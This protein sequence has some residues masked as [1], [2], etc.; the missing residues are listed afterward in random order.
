MTERP[1][2]EPKVAEA[3]VSLDQ[4][5][6]E[7]SALLPEVLKDFDVEYGAAV[8]EVVA[9]VK[10]E[11]I[12]AVCRTLKTDPTVSL[13]YLRCISCVDYEERLEV[14]YHLFSRE[15][16][17]RLVLK[18]SV[19]PDEP[20]VPSVVSIWSGADWF[21]REGHELYGV[22]FQE[23]PNLIPLLLWEGFDGYPG[24]KSFPFHEY[25]EW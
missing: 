12:P 1:K 3:P 16:S 5:G 10:S 17:Y 22:V 13:S 8:D 19:S 9:T 21:E 25:D 6:E 7:L 4:K 24:R 14:V 18:T 15:K 11:D 23:H 2:R 20:N